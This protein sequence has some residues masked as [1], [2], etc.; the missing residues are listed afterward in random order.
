MQDRIKGTD[1][2]LFHKSI[3]L[4]S[5]ILTNATQVM[6]KLIIIIFYFFLSF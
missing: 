3:H 4:F 6:D 1:I 5:V 2:E